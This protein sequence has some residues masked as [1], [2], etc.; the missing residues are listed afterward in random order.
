MLTQ[1]N[2]QIYS[3]LIF[4][5]SGIVISI[6]FD[7]FRILRKSFKTSDVIT[8]LE[9]IVFWILTGLFLIYIILRFNYGEIRFYSFLA[10]I[11]GIIIYLLTLSRYF[12]K[13][14]VKV[15]DTFRIIFKT[16]IFN[17]IY[18]FVINFKKTFKFLS[19][20][21]KKRWRK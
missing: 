4:I 6:A 19:K 1:I 9:D 3:F 12:V 7:I 15:L 8:V 18:L 20:N 17:P 21:T 5:I 14:S 11:L 13:Y 10:L 2:I 16:T